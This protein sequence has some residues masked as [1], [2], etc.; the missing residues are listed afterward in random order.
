MN[1]LGLRPGLFSWEYFLGSTVGQSVLQ[2]PANVQK[3][4]S[5]GLIRKVV[6]TFGSVWLRVRSSCSRVLN[7][8]MEGYG[9][10]VW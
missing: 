2:E 4:N 3:E 10:K 9:C 5:P 8:H 6:R 7:L 1:F